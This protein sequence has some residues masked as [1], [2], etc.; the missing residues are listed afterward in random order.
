MQMFRA[1]KSFKLN[2]KSL[3]EQESYFLPLPI[4]GK[5]LK[6]LFKMLFRTKIKEENTT[7]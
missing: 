1:M 6:T 3:M 4:V 5:T 2:F 7:S